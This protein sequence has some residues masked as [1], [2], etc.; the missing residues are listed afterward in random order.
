MTPEDWKMMDNMNYRDA[1]NYMKAHSK[2]M[3]SF[4]VLKD[5]FSSFFMF[6]YYLKMSLRFFIPIIIT[7]FV[8][9]FRVI[10]I[11]GPIKRPAQ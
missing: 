8:V 9:A 10:K 11:E 4:D 3:N 6:F 1:I 5:Y 2:E 7:A